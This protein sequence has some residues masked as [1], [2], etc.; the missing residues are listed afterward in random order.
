MQTGKHKCRVQ[1]EIFSAMHIAHGWLLTRMASP[2][3]TG[4]QL[5]V[6]W[7]LMLIGIAPWQ[8]ASARYS[9]GLARQRPRI[10]SLPDQEASGMR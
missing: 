4:A 6:G 3:I 1:S 7:A 2:P 5:D 10:C 8:E 9:V